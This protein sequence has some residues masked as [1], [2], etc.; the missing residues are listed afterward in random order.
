MKARSLLRDGIRVVA[1]FVLVVGA[2]IAG[3]SLTASVTAAVAAA[4]SLVVIG[5]VSLICGIAETLRAIRSLAEARAN[6]AEPPAYRHE[7]VALVEGGTD[8]AWAV[9][10]CG[11]ASSRPVHVRAIVEVLHQHAH[12][13]PW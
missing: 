8:H 10:R 6:T 5:T 13:R 3:A 1:P 12:G 11:S 9:C 7:L 4:A 2:L